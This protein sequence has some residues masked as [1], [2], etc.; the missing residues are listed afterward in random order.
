MQKFKNE[1]KTMVI[2]KP[3]ISE[4]LYFINS[5]EIYFFPSIL[6][7]SACKA[8]LASPKVGFASAA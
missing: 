7:L 6:S 8:S 5:L 3:L 4:R 2:K 1:T